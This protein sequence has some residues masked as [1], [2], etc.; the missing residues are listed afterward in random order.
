MIGN[1]FSRSRSRLSTPSNLEAGEL[2]PYDEKREQKYLDSYYFNDPPPRVQQPG[3]Q[4]QEVVIKPAAAVGLAVEGPSPK[5]SERATT[6]ATA[7]REETPVGQALNSPIYNLGS[8]A[9]NPRYLSGRTSVSSNLSDLLRQQ[10]ELDKS[11][12]GL[13]MYSS[14]GERPGLGGRSPSSQSDFS[15]SK[16]PEPPF[17]LSDVRLSDSSERSGYTGVTGVTGITGI[18]ALNTGD[19]FTVDD[20]EF[21]LVPPRMPAAAASSG[22]RMREPSGVSTATSLS[23]YNMDSVLGRPNRFDSVG[24]Q[25]DVTSF[26]GGACY[27][28]AA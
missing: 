16:F 20:M 28:Q 17:A 27:I 10:A 26:I 19:R 2:Q 15:L 1:W 11:V 7:S 23:S 6:V 13:Q 12:A 8:V 3:T 25:Y 24:T 21:A 18:S 5:A 9:G 4:A 22:D 14:A